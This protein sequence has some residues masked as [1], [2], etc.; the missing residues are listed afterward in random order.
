MLSAHIQVPVPLEAAVGIGEK[1]SY[2]LSLQVGHGLEQEKA[3]AGQKRA[4]FDRR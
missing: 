3:K 4:A 2:D 1:T